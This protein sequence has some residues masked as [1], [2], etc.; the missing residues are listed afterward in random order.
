MFGGRQHRPVE[1]GLRVFRKNFMQHKITNIIH[2]NVDDQIIVDVLIGKKCCRFIVDT[3][4][5]ISI[6]K[7]GISQRNIYNSNVTAKSVTGDQLR[8]YGKQNVFVTIEGKRS[9][10]HEFLVANLEMTCDGI[11]GMDFLK[12][13]GAKLDLTTGKLFIDNNVFQMKSGSEDDRNSL[14]RCTKHESEFQSQPIENIALFLN[15]SDNATMTLRNIPTVWCVTITQ[16][17]ILSPMSE[18]LIQ[19]RLKIKTHEKILVPEVVIIEPVELNI[20]GVRVARVL[21]K[22]GKDIPDVVVKIINFSREK[23]I[24]PK[25]STVGIAEPLE[26]QI[27]GIDNKR[28]K[29][30]NTVNYMKSGKV[31]DERIIKEIE[32]KLVH[33]SVDERKVLWPV[34][35]RYAHIFDEPQGKIGCY[36]KIEHKIETG[37]HPPIRKNPYRMPHALKPIVIEQ[38]DEMLTKGIIRPSTSPWSSPVVIVS[39]KSPDGSPKYRFCVDYRA[40]NAIT[41]GDA[42]PLPN[43]VETLDHLHNSVYFTTLDLYSGFHQVRMSPDDIEKTAFSIPDQHYEFQNM[44]FGLCNAPATFQR[45]IDSILMGIKGEEAL[46]YLDDIIVFSSTIEQHA[47]RL[48]KVLSRLETAN[49]YAQLSKCVFAANEV[50]YLGHIVTNNGILPDPKKISSIKKYPK[51]RTVKE[52]QAFLGLVGYYRRFIKNFAEIAKPLTELTKKDVKFNW[53]STQEEAFQTLTNSLCCEPVLKYPD[54]TQPFILSTDASLIAIGAV[55]SQLYNGQEHP[56]AFAS[57]Q[58]N[59]AERNY[60]TTERE[61]L[62]LVWATKYFRCYLYGRKFTVVTDHAALKWMLSLKDPSSRLTRWA[63]R[64]SEF[65]YEVVH[66][67]GKRH[68]NADAL[69]RIVNTIALPY[70]SRREIAIEQQKD[71]F[72][73]LKKKDLGDNYKLDEDELLYNIES[74]EPRLVIPKSMVRQV[75]S[76]H[77]DTLFSGHQGIKRT[78]SLIKDR[79]FWLTLNKDIE[80]YIG[81]CISCNQRKPGKRI[82]APMTKF[83]PVLEPFELVS[84][85]IVGPLPVSKT[86]NRYLLTFIDYLT[87]YCEAIPIPYQSAD[88]IAKEFVLKIVARHGVPKRL[89]TDQGRNFVSSFFTTVCSLLGIRKIQTTPYH[90]QTNGLLERL[91][92]TIA[93]MISHYVASD[94]KNWDEV[95]PYALMAYR[96]ARQTATGYSPHMLLYG[97]E[98]RLP[99]EDDL[100]MKTDVSEDIQL[101]LDKLIQKLRQVRK[102]AIHNTEISRDKNKKYYDKKSKPINYKVGDYVYLHDPNLKKGPRKKFGK[103]WKGPYLIEKVLNDVNYKIK[104]NNNESV[105]VHVNRLKP[106]R[107]KPEKVNRRRTLVTLTPADNNIS[108]EAGTDIEFENSEN[109]NNIL[110]GYGPMLCIEEPESVES[111]T[112]EIQE[113]EDAPLD[114]TFLDPK[115]P[116]WLPNRYEHVD[117]PPHQT[118]SYNLRPRT[119]SNRE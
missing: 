92:K 62:A 47:E 58:L 53:D 84:L 94:G 70:L 11:L 60:S 37:N 16:D 104:L 59:K 42:Y 99:T 67:P 40:L 119:Q 100:T 10:S 19:G 2:D 78:I 101:E 105:T 28:L 55:L 6:I 91:H 71:E 35:Y 79:Y 69:S 8:I 27:I 80:D 64:L 14:S 96:S 90:P 81:K 86:G 65:D 107:G 98:M 75:I 87:R 34:L 115:D 21:S 20:H 116:E 1:L 43:I 109:E 102:T 118:H 24:L 113:D 3:G 97:Q 17:T 38:I 46:V 61:L 23:L 63:L 51:P 31:R 54:F 26:P 45:L 83:K 5:T 74:D 68:T 73:Q 95:V 33:L 111:E 49:L 117:P 50:E 25:N 110:V 36:S 103:N 76:H 13:I 12:R 106:S 39:K 88:I 108:S 52:I 89:L 77:H 15:A 57:R 93:D 30:V 22:V 72:C 18:V 29:N 56:V 114:E 112:S 4:A 32:S 41:R 66:K 82:K 9:F 7:K 85:D 44:P 48:N